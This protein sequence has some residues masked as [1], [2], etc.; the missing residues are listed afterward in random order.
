MFAP[1]SSIFFHALPKKLDLE[2]EGRSLFVPSTPHSPSLLVV[3][4]A[5][6]T[7]HSERHLHAFASVKLF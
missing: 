3:L 2:R 4:K 6:E 1:G 7:N 5:G